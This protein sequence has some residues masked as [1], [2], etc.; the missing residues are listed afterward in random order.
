M[1]E[2]IRRRRP[3][4]TDNTIVQSFRWKT[5]LDSR[6]RTMICKPTRGRERAAQVTANNKH[7]V[8]TAYLDYV[9]LGSIA[10]NIIFPQ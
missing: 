6:C 4:L 10:Y 7:N 3:V 9:M 8:S 2:G 1:L 5:Q